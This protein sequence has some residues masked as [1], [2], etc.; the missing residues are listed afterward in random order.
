MP[1]LYLQRAALTLFVVFILFAFWLFY[2]KVLLERQNEY[3]MALKFAGKLLNALLY[4][5]YIAV[6][7]LELRSHRPEFIVEIVRD[8]DGE[9]QSHLIGVMSVQEAAVHVLR[10]YDARFPSYNAYLSKVGGHSRFRSGLCEQFFEAV[11]SFFYFGSTI[12]INE[13]VLAGSSHVSSGFKM[14][15]IEGLGDCTISESNAR[16][17]ME[18]AS[19]RRFGGHNERFHETMEWERRV[20]KCKYRLITATEDAFASVQSIIANNQQNKVCCSR[21]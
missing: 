4:C 19:K 11:S 2:T 10:I 15:D 17:L 13:P 16:L 20:Q 7:V 1:R 12:Y 18:A 6:T 5:H 8:P 9:S 21:I 14:Y 3:K